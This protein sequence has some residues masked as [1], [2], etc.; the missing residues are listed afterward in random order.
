MQPNNFQ[1]R[2]NLGNLVSIKSFHSF[3]EKKNTLEIHFLAESI[4]TGKTEIELW[5]T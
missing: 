3:C 1:N 5:K 4:D 2:K